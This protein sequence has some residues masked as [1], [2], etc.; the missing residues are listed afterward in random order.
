VL[1]DSQFGARV[2]D[3]GLSRSTALSAAS[4]PDGDEGNHYYRSQTGIFPVRWTAPEAM[5]E[6]KFTTAS[7][8][9][10]FG[11]VMAEIFQDGRIPY[12]GIE[13]EA[14][15]RL[16]CQGDRLERPANCPV[17]MYTIMRACWSADP[18]NR[19][20]FSRLIPSLEAE[21]GVEQR[22]CGSGGGGSSNGGEGVHGNSVASLTARTP[23]GAG[24]GGYSSVSSPSSVPRTPSG[25]GYAGYSSAPTPNTSDAFRSRSDSVYLGFDAEAAGKNDETRL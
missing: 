9:W 16:V 17:D 8:V 3:F 7:D 24:H 6:L 23:S 4:K 2:A 25:A 21:L 12:A 1:V 11:I 22:K 18:T 5:E 10:S 13:T 20:S 14:V 15:M 19:P